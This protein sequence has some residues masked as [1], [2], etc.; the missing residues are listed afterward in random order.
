MAPPVQPT[1]EQIEDGGIKTRK[2]REIK[3]ARRQNRKGKWWSRVGYEG[4]PYC[5]RCSE[6]FRDHIIR[7][8]SNSAGCSRQAPC[9]DCAKILKHFPNPESSFKTMQ[10]KER[11]SS[12]ANR[13][14]KKKKKKPRKGSSNAPTEESVLDSVQPA[15]LL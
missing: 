14:K 3:G 5:Q 11:I 6:T 13:K 1:H 9:H 2:R 15:V 4:P 10:S 7:L 12:T 8:M